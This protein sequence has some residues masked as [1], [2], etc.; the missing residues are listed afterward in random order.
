M[1]LPRKTS[2]SMAY[3]SEG[4]LSLL[5]ARKSIDD[6]YHDESS[7]FWSINQLG[8]KVLPFFLTDAHGA[9][10]NR[11]CPCLTEY[12]RALIYYCYFVVRIHEWIG[13]ERSMGETNAKLMSSSASAFIIGPIVIQTEPTT[14]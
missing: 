5:E 10:S 8:K 9:V 6:Y 1:T 11:I 14:H 3:L 7:V 12:E 2:K 13:G 4:H